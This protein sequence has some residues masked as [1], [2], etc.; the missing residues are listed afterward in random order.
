MG[1]R[2]SVDLTSFQHWYG[3]S[4]VSKQNGWL[5]ESCG[6]SDKHPTNF[7]LELYH[8]GNEDLRLEFDDSLQEGYYG[9]CFDGI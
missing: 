8:T 5:Q 2:C 9:G 4:K 3:S 6:V 1:N 7:C